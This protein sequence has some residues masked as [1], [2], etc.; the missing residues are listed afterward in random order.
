MFLAALVGGARRM[1]MFFAS[2]SDSF[3]PRARSKRSSGDA[4]GASMAKD[5]E[6]G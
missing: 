1:T 3:W 4:A 6:G 2:V 5:G